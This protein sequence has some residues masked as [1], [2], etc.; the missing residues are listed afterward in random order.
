MFRF[1]LPRF[2]WQRRARRLVNSQQPAV[3]LYLQIDA[4]LVG[5]GF[6]HRGYSAALN[7]IAERLEESIV[8]DAGAPIGTYTIECPAVWLRNEARR[9]ARGEKERRR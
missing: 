6:N 3:P 5:Q 9:A 2:P 7:L 1:R 4:V 8:R